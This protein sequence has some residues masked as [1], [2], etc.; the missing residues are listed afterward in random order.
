[1]CG[2]Q[3]VGET[4]GS[5]NQGSNAGGGTASSAVSGAAASGQAGRPAA[6][7]RPPS[8]QTSCTIC[9]RTPMQVCTWSGSTCEYPGM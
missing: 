6:S 3:L 5:G 1:M 4:A 9:G 2:S 8:G 7:A